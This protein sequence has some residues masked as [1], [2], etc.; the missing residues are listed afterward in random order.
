MQLPTPFIEKYQRLLG[1]EASAFFT[2]L[3]DNQPV[4]GFRLNI[5]KPHAEAMLAK[6]G[7]AAVP[8]PYAEAAYLAKSKAV[9]C[10]IKLAMS[11]VKNLVR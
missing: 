8:A 7:P 2:A 10:S 4:K 5:A 11:T 3:T 1:E 9:R 6:Y